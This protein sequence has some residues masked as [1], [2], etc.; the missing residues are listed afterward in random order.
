MKNTQPGLKQYILLGLL[1]ISAALPAS[2]QQSGRET[3]SIDTALLDV[4]VP[5]SA[6][7]SE[8]KSEGYWYLGGTAAQ[9]GS[10]FL[11]PKYSPD[12]TVANLAGFFLNTYGSSAMGYSLYAYLADCGKLNSTMERESYGDL[13]LA[14]YALSNLESVYVLPIVG[15]TTLNMAYLLLSSDTGAQRIADWYSS[16]SVDFWG[17]TM[18]PYLATTLYLSLHAVCMAGVA[19]GE[20][21]LFRGILLNEMGETGSSI[22]FGASHLTNIALQKIDRRSITTVLLQSAFATCFGFLQ[23]ERVKDNGGSLSEAVALHY[24]WNVCMSGVQLA[25]YL[26]EGKAESSTG[27]KAVSAM[28]FGAGLGP[29]GAVT[30]ALSIGL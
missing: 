27:K 19:V 30:I 15:L 16:G 29:G 5:G 28:N 1:A 7:L 14:P 24:W 11:N 21:T 2:A 13:L 20:E 25:Q 4:I 17:M 12:A 26:A 6:Q 8:G 22:V 10:Y 23:S 18:N 3:F 9:I